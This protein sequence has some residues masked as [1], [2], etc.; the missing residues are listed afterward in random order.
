M[1]TLCVLYMQFAC[2][3]EWMYIC[4]VCTLYMQFACVRECMY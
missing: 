1:R 2:V 4:T 3:G